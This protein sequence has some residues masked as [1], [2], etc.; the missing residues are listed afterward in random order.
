M[1]DHIINIAYDRKNS[2]YVAYNLENNIFATGICVESA[3][4]AYRNRYY[5]IQREIAEEDY[6]EEENIL[7]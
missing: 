3:C 2:T 4:Q 6:Y 1:S 5:E 7:S